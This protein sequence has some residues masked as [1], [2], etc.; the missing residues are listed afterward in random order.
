MNSFLSLSRLLLPIQAGI[1]IHTHAS[2]PSLDCTGSTKVSPHRRMLIFYRLK[3]KI[4]K[5]NVIST[6]H[7]VTG[8]QILLFIRVLLLSVS[9]FLFL[10][11]SFSNIRIILFILYPVLTFSLSFSIFLSFSL[12]YLHTSTSS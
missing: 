7:R 10:L 4:R 5:E 2:S 9:F 8:A 11:I 12:F 1:Y 6:I 3:A